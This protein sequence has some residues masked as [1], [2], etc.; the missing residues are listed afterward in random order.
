MK[1]FD[2]SLYLV[3]D[4]RFLKNRLL[5]DVILEA[6][7][8]G[9]TMVQLREKE[10]PENEFFSLAESLHKILLPLNIPLII[11][12]NPA[13]ALAANSEGVH[14]GARDISA[15]TAREMLGPGAIIGYS[16]DFKQ[17]HSLKN[18]DYIGVGPIFPTKTKID[19]QTPLKINGLTLICKKFDLPAIA[20]GGIEPQ[21]ISE[22]FNAGAKGIAVVS[23]I[24]AHDNIFASAERYSREIDQ[25]RKNV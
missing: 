5:N 23:G 10:C 21:H 16:Y 1:V 8:G 9:V 12:D 4:R 15:A 14:L 13:V 22:V 7:D 19:A 3:T 25:W 2:L 17:T 18:V 6:I 24:L 11:N 20:I